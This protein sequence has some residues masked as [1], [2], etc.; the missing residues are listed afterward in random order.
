MS[1]GDVVAPHPHRVGKDHVLFDED[2]QARG[3]AAHVDAGRAQFLLIFHQA[4]HARRR[5]ARWQDARE[6][7][8]AALDAMQQRFDRVG[9]DGQHVH[10]HRE[11]VADSPRGSFR[12]VR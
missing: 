1:D 10:V 3:A 4:R 9:L 2:R 5:K 8:V 11:P 12:P 6:F 7:Q